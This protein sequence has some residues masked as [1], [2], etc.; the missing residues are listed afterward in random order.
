MSLI[1][2]HVDSEL[3]I[4]LKENPIKHYFVEEVYNRMDK[5]ILLGYKEDET[6]FHDYFDSWLRNH[7]PESKDND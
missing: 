1:C 7:F 3:Q 2:E 6:D 4:I 5:E